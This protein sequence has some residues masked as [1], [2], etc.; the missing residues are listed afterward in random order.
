MEGVELFGYPVA[1]E[2]PHLWAEV[3]RYQVW[4]SNTIEVDAKPPEGTPVTV[5]YECL[6]CP[7]RMERTE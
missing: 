4:S 7:E 3:H 5:V 2:C 6:Y 1:Y